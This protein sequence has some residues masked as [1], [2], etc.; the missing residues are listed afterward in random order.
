M[1]SD[2]IF[3]AVVEQ[4]IKIQKFHKLTGDCLLLLEE[5]NNLCEEETDDV[6]SVP[7]DEVVDEDRVD[8]HHRLTA[9]HF[10]QSPTL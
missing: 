4:F 9:D 3:D 7:G 10:S 1:S 5:F 2:E 6:D 8:G